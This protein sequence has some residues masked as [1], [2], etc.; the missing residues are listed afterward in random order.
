[1]NPFFGVAVAAVLLN[2]PLGSQDI[3]GVIIIT[4]GIL[5]VQIS[6]QRAA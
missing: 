4:F 1:L 2:E 5:A 3:L 6:R